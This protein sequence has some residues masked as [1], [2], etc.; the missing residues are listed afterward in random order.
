MSMFQTGT[1][2]AVLLWCGLGAAAAA[3]DMPVV[4]PCRLELATTGSVEWRGLYGRGYDVLEPA[5]SF[6]PVNVIVRHTG[7]ACRFFLTASAGPGGQQLIGP[8]GRLTYDILNEPQGRSV[9]T[10]DYLGTE[11]SRIYGE[12]GEGA[13]EEGKA[14]YVAIPADQFVSGGRYHST[15][16]LRAFRM[17]ANGP[18]LAGE[19]PIAVNTFVPSV[20]KVNLASLPDGVRETMIDFGDLT[21]PQTQTFKLQIRTNAEISL[22]LQSSH[23]GKL[24]HD[25]GF[26]KVPYMVRMRGQPINMASRLRFGRAETMAS[27]QL[28]L[29][30]DLTIAGTSGRLPAGHYSDILLVTITVQ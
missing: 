25:S 29:P 14:L 17:G 19:A 12:F 24:V 28:D 20:A 18:E 8:A 10:A 3:Q 15:A 7:A 11:T 5:E 9:L 16:L 30:I 6:E 21:V 13:A 26:A 23:G 27:R 2:P 1:A 22:S 4:E